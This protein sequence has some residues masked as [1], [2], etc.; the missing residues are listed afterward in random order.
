MLW[1][2]SQQEI[3]THYLET[4]YGIIF[5]A[6]PHITSSDGDALNR[7]SNIVRYNKSNKAA[8]DKE[9]LVELAKSAWEF[10]RLNLSCP[11]LSCFEE[12]GLKVRKG[13]LNF[14]V[15]VSRIQASSAVCS[16]YY[17]SW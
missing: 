3:R 1:R 12:I 7:L 9:Q 11:I 17:D 6:T 16:S 15:T 10:E 4:I 8:C 13:L 5:L 2:F 14:S